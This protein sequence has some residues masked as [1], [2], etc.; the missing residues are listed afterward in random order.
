MPDP[1][2][3]CSFANFANMVT[4]T[5]KSAGKQPFTLLDPVD[6]LMQLLAVPGPSGQERDVAE[7]VID[8]LVRAGADRSDIVHD[9][10]HR[11]SPWTGE[12]GN[13]IFQLPGTIRGP[14]RLLMAHLDTV[15]IC[16]GSKPVRL[17]QTIASSDP[18]KGVGA[19][20][21]AGVA[22]VLSTALRL[23]T[24]RVSHPPLTFLWTVQEEVGLIGARFVKASRLGKPKWA[25]NWDGGP[26][27]AATIGATGGYRMDIDVQGLASHAGNA[28]EQGV[29]AIVISAKA[30]AALDRDGWHGKVVKQRQSG[31]SNIG[32]IQ[33]GDATNVVTDHVRLRGEARSHSGAFRRKI[34]QAMEKAFRDAASNTQN[35]AGRSGQVAFHGHLDYESYRLAK[36]EPCVQAV[37]AAIRAMGHTPELRVTNGGL[38]ANWMTHHGIPTVSLG[39]G[40]RHPHTAN[41]YVDL[42]DFRVACELAWR[43]AT[44]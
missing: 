1:P 31:T 8:Y 10:A 16:V 21:R 30:I 43:L 35:S 18:S 40:Q 7:L 41:E 34:V 37:L 20:N 4:K 39:C 14:R 44:G 5:R 29:S 2:E 6:L 33:G 25:Y 3:N 26:A 32:V 22:V 9:D 11:K 28:P 15:P 19:D 24:E 38:D 36:E 27:T 23:L 17:G 12:I 13:L 42:P